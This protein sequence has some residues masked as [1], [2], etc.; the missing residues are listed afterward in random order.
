[1]IHSASG[2]IKITL[3]DKARKLSLL[4]LESS[5]IEGIISPF[6]SSRSV[7]NGHWMGQDPDH[8]LIGYNET[9]CPDL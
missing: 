7:A 8:W 4:A 2:D 5:D 9:R 1:M 6:C 3:P